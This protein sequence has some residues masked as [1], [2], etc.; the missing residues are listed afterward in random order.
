MDKMTKAE[1]KKR[2]EII[3]ENS[4]AYD[5]AEIVMNDW[6][7]Y[8]KDRTYIEVRYG[9]RKVQPYGYID[10]ETG[11][12]VPEKYGD[13][14]KN[15]TLGGSEFKIEEE[16]EEVEEVT[17]TTEAT[18]A[19]EATE[20]VEYVEYN[21][22]GAA[23][24]SAETFLGTKVNFEY[25]YE[26]KMVDNIAY[27]DGDNINLGKELFKKEKIIAFIGDKKYEL[28]KRI[29]DKNSAD[30]AHTIALKGGVDM[31]FKAWDGATVI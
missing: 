21:E 30:E 8:G 10:N 16:V 22:D 28:H 15:Y 29:V 12:Y 6:Q 27:A 25:S 26:K 3:I 7:N 5:N 20:E 1:A 19:T 4:V 13:L 9:R 14:R 2:L 31:F 18:E 17:E 11:E 23:M 24:L